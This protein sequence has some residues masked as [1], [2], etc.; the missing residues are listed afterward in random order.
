[1][2]QTN[3]KGQ[4]VILRQQG[5]TYSEI[6]QLLNGAVSV[7]QCKRWLKGVKKKETD[8]QKCLDEII[9]QSL[10]PGG[11]TDYQ[12]TGI[13]FK[14]YPEATPDKIRYLKRRARELNRDCIIRPDWI[15]PTAPIKCHT[16]MNAFA[17]HLMDTVE[18]M[19]DDFLEIYPHSNKWAVKH[20]MLKL[21]FSSKISQ[22][23]LSAR[24]S[25][26]EMLAELLEDKLHFC[27]PT[28]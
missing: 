18:Q 28:E 21:S 10:T 27:T 3:I 1:M 9:G 14:Y 6:S 25:R 24:I 2:T 26:N 15:D 7:D 12:A 5:H 11:I 22:E 8:N 19:V 16:S 17:L 4:A 23:P 20:E 13:I